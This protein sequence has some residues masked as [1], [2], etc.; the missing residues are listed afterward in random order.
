LTRTADGG[1]T[2]LI[3]AVGRTHT[4]TEP[5]AAEAYGQALLHLVTAAS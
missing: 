3:E 2:V 5:D 1:W 4:F